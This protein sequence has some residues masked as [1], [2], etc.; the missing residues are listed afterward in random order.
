MKS[1]RREVN[2][3]NVSLLDILCGA[4]GAFCFLMITLLPYWHPGGASAKDVEQQYQQAM[5]ELKDLQ[6]KL[7]N[8]PNA[9]PDLSKQLEKLLEEFRRKQRQLADALNRLEQSKREAKKLQD[10]NR[11]LR[12]RRPMVVTMQWL[13]RNHNV[14][15]YLRWRGQNRAKGQPAVDATKAQG[16][17]FKGDIY[18]NCGRGP[19]FESWMVRDF[20]TGGEV[21]VYYK[22]LA[23]NGNPQ[24]A[25]IGPAALN[26][27][28]GFYRL[29]STSIAA[30][31]TAV[32]VGTAK[33]DG[34]MKL[35]FEPAPEFR[36]QFN[37][38]NNRAPAA[39]ERK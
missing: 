2:I 4:L 30:E 1:R 16:I 35:S 29:P 36:E 13:S 24:P 31:K 19:C 18:T 12:L 23:A 14:D 25:Q 17:Y 20:P 34:N 26:H 22:F 3:F 8:L 11:D 32:M 10:E 21:E 38:D 37:R 9:G 27:E 15:I 7:R 39:Q 5:R 33:L 28:G 6:E